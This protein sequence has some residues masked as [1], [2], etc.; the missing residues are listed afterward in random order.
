[1]KIESPLTFQ[2]KE[3]KQYHV[4]AHP[5]D[6]GSYALLPGDPERVEKI[7]KHLDE[8]TEVA[9]HREFCVW[10]GALKGEK[11]TVCSTGIGG[12][13]TAIAVEELSRLGV[14]TFLRIGSSGAIQEPIRCGD[15]VISSAAVR[16]DGASDRYVELSYPAYASYEV[17]LALVEAAEKLGYNYHVGV[18]VSSSSFYVGEGRPGFGGYMPSHARNLLDDFREAR[19]LNLEMECAT[20]FVLASIFGLRAGA[21]C[22]VYDNMVT[23]EV[24][25]S[26]EEENIEVAM[27]ATKIL[28]DWDRAKARMGKRYFYPSLAR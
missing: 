2:T 27:E 20:L 13:S 17:T 26:G 24:R 16:H 11:V 19:I 18:T 8:A 10:T 28:I 4:R 21:T 22:A 23:G 12:P 6:I 5:E 9:Y 7:A 25:I 3:G 15:L 1:M 14:R